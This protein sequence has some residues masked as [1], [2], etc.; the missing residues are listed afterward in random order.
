MSDILGWIGAALVL[1]A[2]GLVSLGKLPSTS[3]L[4]AGMNIVG[5]ASLAAS[6]ALDRRW[7]FVVLNSVWLMIGVVSLA[8]PPRR[9]EDAPSPDHLDPPQP[10]AH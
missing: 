10:T 3:A 2:Y 4:W 8:R 9:V 7:P 5:A 1:G 6:A